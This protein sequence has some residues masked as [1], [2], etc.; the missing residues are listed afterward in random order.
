M[1]HFK[2]SL[3]LLAHNLDAC[4][5]IFIILARHVFKNFSSKTTKIGQFWTPSLHGCYSTAQTGVH[6]GAFGFILSDTAHATHANGVPFLVNPVHDHIV[7]NLPMY[8][9]FPNQHSVM[10]LNSVHLAAA[11]VLFIGSYSYYCSTVHETT[12]LLA[13]TV[14]GFRLP[15]QVPAMIIVVLK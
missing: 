7:T 6:F 11:L 2:K 4:Q 3:L 10:L 14:V 13:T 5:P 1:P 12:L 8:P 9:K 15:Q